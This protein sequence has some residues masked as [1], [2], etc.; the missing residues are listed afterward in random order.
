M[1]QRKIKNVE[2]KIDVFN[3]PLVYDPASN[4]G[5]WRDAFGADE[6]R[7]LYLEIGCGKGRFITASALAHPASLY[8]GFEGHQSVLYRA[9]QRA[10]AG[11]DAT[12][13]ELDKIAMA[14]AGLCDGDCTQCGQRG[15]DD[16]CAAKGGR[17]VSG[18]CAAY[19][20][21][22]EPPDNLR[23]CAEYILDM[24]DFFAEGELNGIYLNFSD[25][26]PKARQEKRR[27]T[28]PRYLNG[29]LNVLTESG[30]LRFKTDNTDFFAYSRTSIEDHP[31]LEITGITE[32]LHRSGYAE[33]NV[34]TE[35]ERRYLNLQRKINYLEAV[36]R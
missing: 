17:E 33:D 20:G 23:L 15:I 5:R 26:W 35:Y 2:V 36:K 12:L 18:D 1:R 13:T 24:R 19:D 9:L 32:D 25:P 29:Y 4:K 21:I 6:N 22:L 27:L 31:G 28:S 30:F 16:D 8:L 3:E 7:P 11:P 14:L 34:M 10:Y